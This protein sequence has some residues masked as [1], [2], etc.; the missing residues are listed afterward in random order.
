VRGPENLLQHLLKALPR[1]TT[2]VYRPH[3]ARMVENE[4]KQSKLFQIDGKKKKENTD[5]VR[6][7][8]SPLISHG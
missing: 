1:E 5:Q 6:D 4:E 2:V 8:F 3:G 7:I